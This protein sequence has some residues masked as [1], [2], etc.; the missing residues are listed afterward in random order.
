LGY[1]DAEDWPADWIVIGTD[2]RGCYVLDL[3]TLAGGDAAVCYVEDDA[4]LRAAPVAPSFVAFLARS[5]PAS[6]RGTATRS[7]P[8]SGW[9]L[10]LRVRSR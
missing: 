9:S 8:G 7:T 2:Y 5:P 3:A 6:A 1:A 10:A 4:D